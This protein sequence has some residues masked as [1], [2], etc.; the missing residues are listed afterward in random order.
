MGE[1]AYI[2]SFSSHTKLREICKREGCHTEWIS[3]KE[4]S[5]H[6]V[7]THVC[8]IWKNCM[9]AQLL[10][11]VWFFVTPW[12]VACQAPLSLGFSRQ[13]CWSGLLFPSPEDL[14]GSGIEP[15]SLM[16]PALGSEF[17]TTGGKSLPVVAWVQFLIWEL[18]SYKPPKVV[19]KKKKDYIKN[20]F[21]K[22]HA[23]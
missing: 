17:F 7:L 13:E 20:T 16:S 23:S 22:S 1:K 11:C 5:R 10:S 21:L 14:P 3:R 12:T 4:K 15:A 9:C 19:G 18:R 8:G 2:E 6:H